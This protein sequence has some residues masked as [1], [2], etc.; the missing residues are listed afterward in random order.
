MFGGRGRFAHGLDTWDLK[1]AEK[2]EKP[3]KRFALVAILFG[4]LALGV[5]TQ[6]QARR[7]YRPYVYRPAVV[8]RP[9]IAPPIA[10]P[11]LRPYYPRSYYYR[12]FYGYPAFG[13]GFVQPFPYAAGYYGPPGVSISIGGGG[14]VW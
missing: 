10:P 4:V 14:Y 2:K 12:P 9:Y 11:I 1:R 7:F 8:Y 13:A 5:S 6:A 3:M